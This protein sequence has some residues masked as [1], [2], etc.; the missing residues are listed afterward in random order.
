MAEAG[1]L[2][3]G[4]FL[5]AAQVNALLAGRG[6]ELSP[7][8]DGPAQVAAPGAPVRDD[9]LTWP[10]YRAVKAAHEARQPRPNARGLLDLWRHNKPPEIF[11]VLTDAVEYYD[12]QG[13]VKHVNVEA[14]RGRLKT[15]FKREPDGKR[16][17]SGRR[18]R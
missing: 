4:V 3:Q 17:V 12:S 18:G 1:F 15:T 8:A 14:L 2:L 6:A 11:K 5:Q 7:L 9:G 10:I 16:T 13:E